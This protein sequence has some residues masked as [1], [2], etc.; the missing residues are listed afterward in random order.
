MK[1]LK[2]NL[3]SKRAAGKISKSLQ[4]AMLLEVS[5]HPKPGNVHR[6]RDY[7]ETLFEHYLASSVASGPHFEKAAIRG[8]LVASGAISLENGHVGRIIRDA[9]I[10]TLDA[11]R[12]GNTSLGTLTLLIPIAFAAGV[13]GNENCIS[14]ARLRRNLRKVLRATTVSDSIAFYDAIKYAKPGGLGRVEV[15]DVQEEGSKVEIQNGKMTL[16]EVFKLAANRDSICSEWVTTYETTFELGYPYFDSQLKRSGNIN[17]ATVNTYL[18]V[19]SRIPDTLIARKA[20]L[21]KSSWVSKRALHIIE[22]GG[23]STSAGLKEI[24]RFD[25]E[26]RRNGHLLNP[27]ATAD[28]IA[29]ILSLVLLSGYRP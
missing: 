15:L 24:R 12:G 17:E 22:L 19:L 18:K 11:Q 28:I 1:P 6:T 26:L 21:Q 14:I 25:G 10:D 9:A 4:L 27:G 16:F 7:E 20:G 29:A 23:A 13:T 3:K 5:A 2:P 8:R